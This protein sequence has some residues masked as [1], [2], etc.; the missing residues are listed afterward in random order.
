M[1][2]NVENYE[3]PPQRLPN[4]EKTSCTVL[5]SVLPRRLGTSRQDLSRRAKSLVS[6][7]AARNNWRMIEVFYFATKTA[8]L[9]LGHAS[10][11]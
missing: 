5:F 9:A 1:K 8:S 4:R 3:R 2:S 6:Q 11:I 10:V 7:V